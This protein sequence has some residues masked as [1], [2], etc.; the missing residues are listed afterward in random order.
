MKIKIKKQDKVKEFNLISKWEDVTLEKWLALIDFHKLNKSK[1]AEET[2][3][4]LSNIPKKLIKEL[5]L[6]DVAVIMSKI[7]ELQQKQDSSLKRVIEIEGKRYGFHPDLDSITLGEWSD[8]ETMIKNNVEKHLP[9]VMAILYRPI[10]EEQNDIYTIKAYDGNISIRAEQMKK[11]AA[12][13]VQSALVFFYHLGKE[14]L[15]ILPSFL[16]ERLKV[17]KEQLQQN[18]LLKD[19]VTLV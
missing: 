18:H 8:L 6:K 15:L 3:A 9:E 19:G 1:E 14:S 7:S 2:I 4:A 12:E 11:M 13:Q 17:M 16:T 5:E 10:I